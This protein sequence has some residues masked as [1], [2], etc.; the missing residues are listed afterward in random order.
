MKN[1]KCI[2]CGKC[3]V[4]CPVFAINFISERK[5]LKEVLP[6]LI[7]KEINCIELHAL[8][9][10]EDEINEKW[11]DI[12]NLY[13]GI[14]S[15][16][17]DRSKLSNEKLSARIKKMVSL[18]DPYTTIIQ[19]DGS[20]MSGEKDDFKTTLQTVATAEIVQNDTL[21]VFMLL[22]GGTNSKSTKLAKQCGVHANGVAIRSFAR[23]IVREELDRDDFLMNNKVFNKALKKAK[24][25]V[26]VS[27]K[28]LG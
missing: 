8:G 17:I 24:K 1:N 16:C 3:S 18:R 28:Y 12:N 27:L 13:S 26:E 11:K 2:G 22:S 5:N 19:A 4:T 14:L 20:P 15:I 21:P 25:L 23:K 10:N 6:P 7:D 9:E